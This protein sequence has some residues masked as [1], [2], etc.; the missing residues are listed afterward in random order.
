[1][2]FF[3]CIIV[4]FV[5]KVGLEFPGLFERKFL[6]GDSKDESSESEIEMNEADESGELEEAVVPSGKHEREMNIAGLEEY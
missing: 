1:M 5:I 6:C 2:I 3:L 4:F